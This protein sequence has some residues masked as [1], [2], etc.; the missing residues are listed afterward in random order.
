M[1]VLD[2]LKIMREKNVKREFQSVL[3]TEY[4][5][6][7]TWFCLF[8]S[9]GDFEEHKKVKSCLFGNLLIYLL[10]KKRISKNDEQNHIYLKIDLFIVGKE[11]NSSDCHFWLTC[12]QKESLLVTQLHMDFCRVHNASLMWVILDRTG[13]RPGVS[14]WNLPEL[15]W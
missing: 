3:Q 12:C 15:P 14:W 6:M 4:D 11:R 7:H 13:F 5:L 9:I 8:T 1:V 10:L 2:T